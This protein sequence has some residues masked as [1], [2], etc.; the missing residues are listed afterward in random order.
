M[1]NRSVVSASFESAR[2]AIGIATRGRP[3]ILAETLLHLSRQTRPAECV[4]VA[5]LEPGDIAGVAEQLTEEQ[6]PK[7]HFFRGSGGSCAQR[8]HLL[9]AIGSRFDVVLFLDDDFYMHRDYLLRLTEVFSLVP[10]ALG[11]T[12]SVIADGAKG[13]GITVA[14]AIKQL[15]AIG[16]V[17]SLAEQPPR[18]AFN[19]YGCNMAFRIAALQQYGVRF[20]ENLPAYGW[21]ED[22][23]FSRRLLPH[24]RLLCIPSALGVHL[25]VKMGRTSGRRFGYSQVANPMYL[26]R[27]GSYPWFRAGCSVARNFVANAFKS[28]WPEAYIDRRGRLLGNLTA[29]LDGLRGRMHPSRILSMR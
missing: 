4:L 29:V 25:G 28:L 11:A 16:D 19:T 2:I 5:Y 12:G 18:D 27:K 7:V 22:L 6:F 10:G 1:L 21:Y 26:A 20:D 9:D 3:S 17:P 15:D 14:D 13:P 23:D 8:N 24:G